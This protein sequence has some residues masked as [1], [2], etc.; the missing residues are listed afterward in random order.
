M[1]LA[2]PT[3][4]HCSDE[5]RAVMGNGTYHAAIRL[6][7]TE[8]AM[9]IGSGA[10]LVHMYMYSVLTV[11]RHCCNFRPDCAVVTGDLITQ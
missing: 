4:I 6:D 8:S 3:D 5:D 2:N 9:R 11:F 10:G 7:C 1:C